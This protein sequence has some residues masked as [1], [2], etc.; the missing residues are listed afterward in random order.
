MVR[1]R[2]G[3]DFPTYNAQRNHPG[4]LWLATTQSLVGYESLL[5]RDRLWLADFDREVRWVAGQPFW[6]SGRDGSVL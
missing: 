3:R 2:P 6:L 1:G 5:E 4:W